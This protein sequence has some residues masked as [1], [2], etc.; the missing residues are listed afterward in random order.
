MITVNL[1]KTSQP[2]TAQDILKLLRARGDFDYDNDPWRIYAEW[3]AENNIDAT[4]PGHG[5]IKFTNDEDALA[6]KI[7]FGL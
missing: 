5:Y 3:L 7:K 4:I 6:F 2:R 1:T